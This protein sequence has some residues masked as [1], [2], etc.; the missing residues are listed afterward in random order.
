[1]HIKKYT[2]L[3]EVCTDVCTDLHL[4]K[5]NIFSSFVLG[6]KHSTMKVFQMKAFQQWIIW[7]RQGKSQSGLL[8]NKTKQKYKLVFHYV[9]GLRETDKYLI[10]F[11]QRS[12]PHPRYKTL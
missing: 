3:Y 12:P 4:I 10:T 8:E 5:N 6:N 2:L 1:M 11:P 9:L 7:L